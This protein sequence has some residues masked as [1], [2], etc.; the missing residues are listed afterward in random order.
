MFVRNGLAMDLFKRGQHKSAEPLWRES[1]GVYIEVEGASHSSTVSILHNLAALYEAKKDYAEA[2]DVRM[3]AL[4]AL[5]ST[6]GLHDSQTTQA[7]S[8]LAKLLIEAGNLEVAIPDY[9][10]CLQMV[11]EK[12][13]RASTLET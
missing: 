5:E 1:L 11:M 6:V 7:L 2:V 3:K 4:S 10:N 8:A 9:R 13:A 12:L